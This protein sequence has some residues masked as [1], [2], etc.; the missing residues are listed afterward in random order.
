MSQLTPRP[1]AAERGGCKIDCMTNRLPKE[2]RPSLSISQRRETLPSAISCLSLAILY[3][4]TDQ[5]LQEGYELLK[6]Q[7]GGQRRYL[8]YFCHFLSAIHSLSSSSRL[9]HYFHSYLYVYSFRSG[10]KVWEE[11]EV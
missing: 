10:S 5:L 3:F 6:A 7:N 4:E 11:A 1:K 2:G 8:V 9:L